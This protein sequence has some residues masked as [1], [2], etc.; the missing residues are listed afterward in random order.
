MLI[1]PNNAEIDFHGINCLNGMVD[2]HMM[3]TQQGWC[4]CVSNLLWATFFA[5]IISQVCNNQ[6]LYFP[7]EKKNLKRLC[8][9]FSTAIASLDKLNKQPPNWV[10]FSFLII[11]IW[12]KL[13][14]V[15]WR[16]R[17]LSNN[18]TIIDIA[19]WRGKYPTNPKENCSYLMW[20]RR[21]T[22]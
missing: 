12:F 9:K 3:A 6:L 22:E 5:I 13:K 15:H 4:Y 19:N 7:R 10:F 2:V 18:Q 21:N 14:T 11:P 8:D 16:Q 1:W 17:L 20:M